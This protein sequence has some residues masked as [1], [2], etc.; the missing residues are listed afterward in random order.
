MG[1][2]ELSLL[3]KLKRAN[4]LIGSVATGVFWQDPVITVVNTPP[5]LPTDGDRYIVGTAPTGVWDGHAGDVAVYATDT[6]AFATPSD[7]W[8]V[9]VHDDAQFL[10]YNEGAWFLLADLDRITEILH[11]AETARDTI[12]ENDGFIAVSTDLL[13]SDYIGTVA[14]DL[15]LGASSLVKK[16]ADSISNVNAVGDSIANV[17]SVAEALLVITAVNNNKPNINTVATSIS[18]VNIV[19][20][21]IANVNAVAGNKTNIDAVNAN[22]TNIDAVAGINMDVSTVAGISNDVEILASLSVEIQALADRVAKIDALHDKI[23]E[24]DALYG[25]TAE[26]DAL[27]ARVSKIDALNARTTEIDALYAQLSTIAEKEN[28]SNKKST[29]A[30]NSETYYPNQK[31]VNDGLDTK[32]SKSQIAYDNNAPGFIANTLASGAIIERGSNANGEYVKF[33]DGTMMCWRSIAFDFTNNSF[34]YYTYPVGFVST[35]I[36]AGL[37]VGNYSFGGDDFNL[38]Q[39]ITSIVV[40][41]RDSSRWGLLRGTTDVTSPTFPLTLWAIGRWK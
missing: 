35:L 16:V 33:A 5:A 21:D 1:L 24:M 30:E 8:G 34:Q 39:G 18:N 7:R 3:D 37:T 28:L 31:A 6:W 14:N 32:T 27:Y 25:R 38:R 23:A 9:F 26:I 41:T 11:E 4:I 10:L 40:R 13:G 19:G 2:I 17:N 20:G 15:L 22:K 36:G 12:L 29:L